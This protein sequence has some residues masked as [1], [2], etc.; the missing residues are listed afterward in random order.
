MKL[1]QLYHWPKILEAGKKYVEVCE[2][3]AR[4]KTKSQQMKG[5]MILIPVP[6]ECWE[7][8]SMDFITE[9]PVLEGYDAICVVVDK[10]SKRTIYAQ[11][12]SFDCRF[13]RH[14]KVIF[15]TP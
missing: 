7:V 9:L 4:W 15:S 2:T 8:V 14:R 3:C 11:A 12:C 13:E 1:K 5:L 6:E 10:L